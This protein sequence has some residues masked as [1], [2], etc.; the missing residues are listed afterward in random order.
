MTDCNR[1]GHC[2]YMRYNGKVKKCKYLRYT[3]D[4]KSYCPIYHRRL[5]TVIGTIDGVVF[6][7][8]MRS[9][10]HQN[11]PGCPQNKPEWEDA[12]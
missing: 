10:V 5:G 4:K 12:N 2:C 6:R 3:K 11:F 1:T 8:G 7:C 9:D